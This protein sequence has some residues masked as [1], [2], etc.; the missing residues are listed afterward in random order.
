MSIVDEVVK[1]RHTSGE[2]RCPVLCNRLKFPDTGF[3]RYDYFVE[4]LTFT[5]S[6]I[7]E[8]LTKCCSHMFTEEFLARQPVRFEPQAYFP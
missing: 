6:S 7:L 4:F 3:R 8:H 2:N 1:S 5:K